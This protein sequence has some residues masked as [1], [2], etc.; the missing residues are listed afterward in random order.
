MMK[1]EYMTLSD[2]IRETLARQ[3]LFEELHIFSISKSVIILINNQTAF[4]ISEN[5]ANYRQAKHID[6]HY[7]AIKHYIHDQKIEI[8]YISFNYQFIDIFIK[9]FEYSKHLRFCQMM[10]LRNNFEAF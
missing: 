5:P 7:H 10:N 2:V 9:I 8:D 6:I 4:N 1:V 3:Q